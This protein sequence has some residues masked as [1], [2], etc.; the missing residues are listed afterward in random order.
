MSALLQMG[1]TVSKEQISSSLDK[2]EGYQEGVRDERSRVDALLLYLHNAWVKDHGEGALA[3]D[4]AR[5]SVLKGHKRLGIPE[6]TGMDLIL[7][8]IWSKACEMGQQ[9]QA[10]EAVATLRTIFRRKP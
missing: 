3:I 10:V 5:D 2:L 4:V 7:D 1:D 6:E 8:H 9:E